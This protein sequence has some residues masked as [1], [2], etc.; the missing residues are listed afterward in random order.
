MKLR[1]GHCE[2]D[3]RVWRMNRVC[4][5]VCE[6]RRAKKVGVSVKVSSGQIFDFFVRPRTHAKTKLY[7]MY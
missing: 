4:G 5:G 1:F 2:E 3:Y 6:F 7:V